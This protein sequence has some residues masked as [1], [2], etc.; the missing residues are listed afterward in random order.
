[1]ND[2]EQQINAVL[3][4]PEM[5][6]KVQEIAASMQAASAP[7][8]EKAPE[9]PPEG[10]NSMPFPPEMLKMAMEMAGQSGL[11][12]RQQALLS[13]MKPYL[14]PEKCEK[15]RSAMEAA[16]MAQLATM[17]LGGEFPGGSHV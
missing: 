17:L 6:A 7:N 8:P 12:K 4:N 2:F 11:D 13:A 10:G 5:M 9:S 14:S 16:H 15:L 1:M 3:N